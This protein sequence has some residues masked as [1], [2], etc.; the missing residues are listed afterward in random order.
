[1]TISVDAASRAPLAAVGADRFLGWIGTDL[2]LFANADEAR[3][4]TGAPDPATAAA[5]LAARLGRAVVK[6]GARGAYSCDELGAVSFGPSIE[7]AV[8]DTTG[9]GDAFA[10]AFLRATFDGV[11]P[12]DALRAA[13]SLAARACQQIG[14]RP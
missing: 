3:V 10:A 8:Y 14:G 12:G 4:L 5:L 2:L 6:D 1:M 11:E 7:V 9:A 13:N